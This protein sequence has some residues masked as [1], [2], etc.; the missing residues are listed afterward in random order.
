MAASPP[1]G[2]PL[3]LP[4][5]LGKGDEMVG[6]EGLEPIT[7]LAAAN[8]QWDNIGVNSQREKST[9]LSGIY[10]WWGVGLAG[11]SDFAEEESIF[12]PSSDTTTLLI[13]LDKDLA[14]F[15][16][17]GEIS[18]PPEITVLD[19]SPAWDFTFGGAKVLICLSHSLA[20]DAFPCEGKYID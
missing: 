16:N 5:V 10:W 20:L 4:L 2:S 19:I 12:I 13:T 6:F 17:L 11:T 1:I 18:P 8:R 7:T 9:P 15:L 3:Q 14:S